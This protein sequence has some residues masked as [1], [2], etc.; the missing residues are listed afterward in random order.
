VRL[1]KKTVGE[2]A[3]AIQRASDRIR[4]AAIELFKARGYHGTSVRDLAQAV[5]IE[6]ASLYYH[7]PSKQEILLDLFDRTMDALVDGLERAAATGS[8]PEER[9]RAA[10]R[11]HVLF[12]VERQDEAFISHSEL[13][14]L[15]AENR[16]RIIAKRDR[17]E[18]TLRKLL[19]DGIRAGDFDTPDIKL[20]STAILMMCSGVSDWFTRRGRLTADLVADRYSEMVVRLVST[21]PRRP[22]LQAGDG[23][24]RASRSRSHNRSAAPPS[25]H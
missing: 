7:F 14:S 25:A 18:R 19:D 6:T 8:S 21:G 5:R 22:S 23:A 12:H 15:T 10:V 20:T 9:L 11:F 1:A 4:Q 3:T 16:K 17:Y 13:R 24:P 2:P